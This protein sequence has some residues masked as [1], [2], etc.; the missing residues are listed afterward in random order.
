MGLDLVARWPPEWSLATAVIVAAVIGQASYREVERRHGDHPV[1]RGLAYALPALG[2]GAVVSGSLSG[3]GV[4][5]GA[6]VVHG[7][8][9][10]VALPVAVA[11]GAIAGR[12]T[13]GNADMRRDAGHPRVVVVGQ[14]F[15]DRLGREALLRGVAL[16]TLADA[17]GAW[18]SVVLTAA[19][20]SL[21]ARGGAGSALFA[22][23]SGVVL[24]M[25][26]LEAG[27]F[28]GA[29]VAVFAYDVTKVMVVS[30]ARR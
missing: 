7:A 18:P 4:G 22:G 24:A 16:H 9:L 8:L 14:A 21:L 2:V 25:A 27:S 12:R 13:S 1:L 11:A 10:V 17:S 23:A 28:L 29:F 15:V 5:L 30:A 6:L 26:S 20:S 19:V 3:L